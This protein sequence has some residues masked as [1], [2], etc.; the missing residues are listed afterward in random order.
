MATIL[1]CK[2]LNITPYPYDTWM[3]HWNRHSEQWVIWCAEVHCKRLALVASPV[4][5]LDNLDDNV[6]VVPL[7]KGHAVSN[8]AISIGSVKPVRVRQL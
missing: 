7:C 4:K 8:K 6:Y 2:E 5:I 1:N 3:E